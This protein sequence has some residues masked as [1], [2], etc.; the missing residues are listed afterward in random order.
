M[1]DMRKARKK[2]HRAATTLQGKEDAVF[3]VVQDDT[4]AVRHGQPGSIVQFFRDS[5]LVGFDL[6]L[7]RDKE[8]GRDVDL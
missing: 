7:E 8:T 4:V 5:P 3:P 6:N 2:R 1:L